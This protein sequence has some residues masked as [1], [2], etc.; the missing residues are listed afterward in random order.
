MNPDKIIC[1]CLGITNG[2]IQE[3]VEQGASSLAEVQEINGVGTVCGV[4][5][6]DVEHLIDELKAQKAQ[7]SA[8]NCHK[9]SSKPP[10]TGS[11]EP[12]PE[13]TRPRQDGPGGN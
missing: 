8:T 3:A 4:C 6:E 1:N 11:V 12:L 2:M 5:V 10:K 9:T 13:S 7:G